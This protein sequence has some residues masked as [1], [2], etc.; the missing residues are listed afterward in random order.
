MEAGAKRRSGEFHLLVEGE[1]FNFHLLR[2]KV[3]SFKIEGES[4]KFLLLRGKVSIFTYSGGKF[5]VSPLE[6]E[7]FKFLLLRGKVSIFTGKVSTFKIH[8]LIE[9]KILKLICEGSTFTQG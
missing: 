6:G 8:L 2:R 4:F 9:G 3:S 1:S 7:S 5:Q